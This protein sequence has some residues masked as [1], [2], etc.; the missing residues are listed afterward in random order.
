MQPQRILLLVI[1]LA[2]AF[3]TACA[4]PSSALRC[5]DPFLQPTVIEGKYKSQK[6]VMRDPQS[7]TRDII[8]HGGNAD[9]ALA[10]SNDDKKSAR[11]CLGGK[12]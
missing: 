5:A 10:R 12:Q 3:L 7:T 2:S 6:D 1:T 8:D 11:K 9:D 4:T